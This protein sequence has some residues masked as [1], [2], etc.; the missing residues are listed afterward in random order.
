LKEVARVIIEKCKATPTPGLVFL[1]ST[2]TRGLSQHVQRF[3][4][5][6]REEFPP[7]YFDE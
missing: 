5:S 4:R 2:R 6:L 7:V 3:L 1:A